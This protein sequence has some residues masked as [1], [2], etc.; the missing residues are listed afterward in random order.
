MIS[1]SGIKTITKIREV[2]RIYGL[3]RSGVGGE[4]E[5]LSPEQ[6]NKK[7][8]GG[9]AP[10]DWTKLMRRKARLCFRRK[11]AKKEG[12]RKPKY[13]QN[14]RRHDKREAK[15]KNLNVQCAATEYPT[16]NTRGGGGKKESVQN[17]KQ[18]QPSG[19]AGEKLKKKGF[20]FP[21]K[22]TGRLAKQCGGPSGPKRAEKKKRGVIISDGRIQ[23][24]G[25]G[26]TQQRSK[27][28]LSAIDGR[29]SRAKQTRD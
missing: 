1:T 6:K 3:G 15:Q 26:Q 8:P 4:K 20:Q 14:A 18:S 16:S 7:G 9:R 12:G 23:S 21:S 11:G 2:L 29:S 22:Q 24:W 28:L 25:Q 27:G 13:E 10:S 17:I 5:N 19:E